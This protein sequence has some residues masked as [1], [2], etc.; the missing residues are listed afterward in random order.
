[1]PIINSQIMHLS[2]KRTKVMAKKIGEKLW[3]EI[4]D[5]LQ[6]EITRFERALAP[7]YQARWPLKAAQTVAVLQVQSQSS[8]PTFTSFVPGQTTID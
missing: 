4:R 7:D 6:A 2:A 5:D 8:F 3:K 1:V